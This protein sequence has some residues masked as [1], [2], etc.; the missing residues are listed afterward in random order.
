MRV[1]GRYALHGDIASG[2]MATV[3]Y[4]RLLGQAGFSRTVAI[5]RLHAQ[6]AKDPDFV[7]MF[8]DE[9]RLAARI[10]HPNVVSTLDVVARDGELF[11]V[12]E[13]VHG[14]SL[15]RLCRSAAERKE[16]I[17]PRI[18]AAIVSGFL[19]GLHA[20][21]E[22]RN[23]RGEPLELVHRDVS[24]QNVIVGVDGVPRVVDFGV[25]KAVGQVHTTREG[26]L[27]GKLAYMAP[28]QIHGSAVTRKTDVYAASIV[29]WEMLTGT[30]LFARENEAA[31]MLAALTS[32]PA[33]PS[34]I[35]PGLTT[36][37]DR[38]TLR[39]LAREPVARFATAR[40]MAL[41]IEQA[42]DVA[43]PSEVGAWLQAVAGPTLADR[44]KRVAAIES[45]AGGEH[46]SRSEPPS[47][48]MTAVDGSQPSP[49]VPFPSGQTQ[50]AYDTPSGAV[51]APVQSRWPLRIAV[52]VALL[53]AVLI[54]FPRLMP[55][56]G[57]SSAAGGASNSSSPS[58]A[59]VDSAAVT[60]APIVPSNEPIS[61][62]ADPAPMPPATSSASTAST[63]SSTPS[64]TNAPSA[65][66]PRA[67][68]Q[69]RPPGA[70]ARHPAGETCDPPYRVDPSGRK[71]FKLECL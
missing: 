7:A 58:T 10:H 57:A 31:I 36:A 18:A 22:A 20:A 40:D 69:A 28:E 32:T 62:P 6:Y 4:G 70:A 41:A 52:G 54:F 60:A 44:A 33:P 68:T 12:M 15:S 46:H 53:F 2:G 64:A 14:E 51:V 8:L 11:L 25:A 38:V 59:P 71:I 21:H 47:E 39:G 30:R 3:H 67:P 17:A 19:H 29:L 66:R 1:V 24:P 43:L 16:P 61:P 35:V 50:V 9:A 56:S 63:A 45:R 37:L 55:T 26:Q 5:K 49:S 13:Y 48:T 23:E 65:A 27:K 42:V 34:S